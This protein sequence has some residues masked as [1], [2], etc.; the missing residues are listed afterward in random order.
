MPSLRAVHLPRQG[1]KGC[2]A[3][4]GFSGNLSGGFSRKPVGQPKKAFVTVISSRGQIW[5]FHEISPT[6]G[7]FPKKNFGEI[8]PEPKSYLLENPGHVRLGGGLPRKLELL[9]CHRMKLSSAGLSMSLM[10]TKV[11]GKNP[12]DGG[13]PTWRIIPVDVRS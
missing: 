12:W 11:L 2:F 6:T 5:K 8:L 4:R 7:N 13:A 9:N 3:E 10:A 1:P